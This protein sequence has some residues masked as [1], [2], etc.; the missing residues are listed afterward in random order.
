MKR[1]YILI[2]MIVLAMGM[3]ACSSKSKEDAVSE[4]T[5]SLQEADKKETEDT[6]TTDAKTIETK[7]DDVESPNPETAQEDGEVSLKEEEIPQGDPIVGVVEKYEGNTITIRTP[8]DDML[9][10]F[11]TENVPILEGFSTE[12]AH[13]AEGDSRISVGDKV[14]VSYRGLI[15]FDEEHPD[16]AVKIVVITVE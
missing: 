11:S 1:K 8:E 15:D 10:Y 2:F 5:D 6:K 7:A 16:E 12:S 3:T 4:E 14:E 9:Y 13:T